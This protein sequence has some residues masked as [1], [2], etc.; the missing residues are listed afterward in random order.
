MTSAGFRE[1]ALPDV[2]WLD[3]ATDAG[4]PPAGGGARPVGTEGDGDD[5][6]S[7]G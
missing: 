2:I 6:Q 7:A 3:D 5:R 1:G 4:L